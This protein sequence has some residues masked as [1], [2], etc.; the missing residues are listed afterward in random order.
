[1]TKYASGL[2]AQRG[3]A[4]AERDAVDEVLDLMSRAMYSALLGSAEVWAKLD[5]TMPQL[6]V[7]M[8]LGLY[9]SAPV[10]S[11]ASR[12]NVSPP[13]V[14]GILDRLEANKWVQRTNDTQDRRVVRVV[15]TPQGQQLLHEL[16]AAGNE[17]VRATLSEMQP[18]DR[19]ALRQGLTALLDKASDAP[20]EA[21][22][23]RRAARRAQTS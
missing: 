20:A 21:A 17:R 8:L 3:V 13:N 15:L 2:R 1:V 18:S 6:K 5:I 23:S 14:T 7:L 22:D 11:L 12:M 4:V 19:T 9:G 10:S 16:Q